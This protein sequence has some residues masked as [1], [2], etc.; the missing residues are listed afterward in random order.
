[1]VWHYRNADSDFAFL[2]LN[3]LKDD[4]ANIIRYKTDFEI[5]EGNKI[6]EIKSGKFDKGQGAKSLIQNRHF[7]F[8]LAAGDDITDE[9]LLRILPETAYTIRVGNTPSLARFNVKEYPA[10]LKLL[11]TLGKGNSEE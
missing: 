6:L 5:M 7:D 10:L 9:D 8:I 4:L 1:M 3:E 2:R 11:K